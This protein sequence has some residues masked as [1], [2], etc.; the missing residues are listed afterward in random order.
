MLV[1]ELDEA[2]LRFA[3]PLGDVQTLG[4]GV[5][6]SLM[7]ALHVINTEYTSFF[8]V[9]SWRAASESARPSC[10]VR[11]VRALAAN[12]SEDDERDMHKSVNAC[13]DWS[14]GRCMN[15]GAGYVERATG[16]AYGDM[17][18]MPNP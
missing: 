5:A 6:A 15:W 8:I 12:A 7:Q 18:S 3:R 17:R 13:R 11:S 10:A 4:R 1:R 14:R 16:D 2:G 9:L